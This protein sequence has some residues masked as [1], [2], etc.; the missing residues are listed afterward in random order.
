M[1]SNYNHNPLCKLVE[2]SPFYWGMLQ[3]NLSTNRSVEVEVAIIHQAGLH[4]KSWKSEA[5]P[6]QCHTR[7]PGSK[8]L[9]IT[10]LLRDHGGQQALFSCTALFVGGN[11]A[12]KGGFGPWDFHDTSCLAIFLLLIDGH[13]VLHSAKAH[14]SSTWK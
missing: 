3:S 5:H 4:A 1:G 13:A 14:I 8:A 9:L 7:T 11:V 2:F 12:F 10:I 6:L